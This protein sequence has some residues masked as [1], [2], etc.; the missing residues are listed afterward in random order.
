MSL[1][2]LFRYVRQ[3]LASPRPLSCTQKL[4]RC[5]N[6]ILIRTVGFAQDHPQFLN[7]PIV[8][9][10]TLRSTR[11]FDGRYW[12]FYVW[13]LVFECWLIC[14]DVRCYRFPPAASTSS[15]WLSSCSPESRSEFTVEPNLIPGQESVI[16]R[17][18]YAIT[19]RPIHPFPVNRRFSHILPENRSTI[20]FTNPA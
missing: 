6:L 7:I 4:G 11:I 16:H 12:C 13:C 5:D 1:F 9:I 19:V 14:D 8:R 2:H 20:R 18:W 15:T 10:T 17:T 3:P